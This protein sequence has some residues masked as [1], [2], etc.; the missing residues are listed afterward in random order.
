MNIRDYIFINKAKN[1]N[2]IRILDILGFQSDSYITQSPELFKDI[3]EKTNSE[4][5]TDYELDVPSFDLNEYENDNTINESFDIEE[6]TPTATFEPIRITSQI[7]KIWI[8]IERRRK[9]VV[10]F[11]LILTT[12][13]LIVSTT[14][15][16]ITNRNN[17]LEIENL[18][19]SLTKDSN[20]L[21]LKLPTIINV[22]ADEFYSKYDVSN[23]SAELQ[24]IESTVMEYERNLVNRESFEIDNDL[25]NNL[26]NIFNLIDELDKVI[27]YRILSSEILIYNDLL[28]N[29][30]ESDIDILS[31]R[32]SAISAISKLNYDNLPKIK[33][34][35][36]HIKLL[37]E[38]LKSAEDLHGRLIAALRNNETEV[39]KSLIVAIKMNK[40]IEQRSFKE[41]LFNFKNDKLNIYSEL[42]TLP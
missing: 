32:L 10:P 23:S 37:D 36:K 19:I 12:I 27:S 14:S 26:T 22:S 11:T 9:W 38:S 17:Q 28:D 21:I 24:L 35:E 39:A 20:D 7:K 31:S 18:Y 4:I 30:S 33:E 2:K 1:S 41:A 29:L 40:E 34:F 42:V 5:V 6:Q 8:D 15:I 16:F 25:E 13:V 3:E